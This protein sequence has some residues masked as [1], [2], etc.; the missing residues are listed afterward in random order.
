MHAQ[1]ADNVAVAQAGKQR[2]LLLNGLQ[3][4]D[5]SE[6]AAVHALDSYAGACTLAE[7]WAGKLAASWQECSCRLASQNRQVLACLGVSPLV[8]LARG[9]PANEGAQ[10]EPPA[11]FH[12]GCCARGGG[13]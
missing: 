9:T 1:Q 5:A 3:L 13:G 2:S 7:R 11:N 4:C 12:R 6:A 10:P 8:H